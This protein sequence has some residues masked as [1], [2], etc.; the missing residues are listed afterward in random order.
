[1]AN[2]AG[3]PVTATRVDFTAPSGSKPLIFESRLQTGEVTVVRCRTMPNPAGGRIVSPQT[4]IVVPSGRAFDLDW[5]P[6]EG[7][8]IQSSTIGRG[9][10]MLYEANVPAWKR[11]HGSPVI[12]VMAVRPEFLERIGEREFASGT[13][14]HLRTHVGF[15]DPTADNLMRLAERELD[16]GGL[17]GRLFLEGLATALSV[18]LLQSYAGE[19]GPER[20]HGGLAAAALK[21]VTDY[22][23]AHL[24]EELALADLATLAGLSAHHFGQAFKRTT[25]L[26]PHQ[27]VIHCR[28]G[29]A[30]ELLRDPA[31]TVAEVAVAVGFSNQSHLTRHF[32]RLTG[33]T[34][35]R[36]RR[37]LR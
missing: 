28:V 36:F 21:Q 4:T 18:H 16:E 13:T 11:W 1:M 24:A 22:I 34:P 19:A 32:R 5:R 31:L 15:D 14:K 29:R 12:V 10:V 6:P 26:P 2:D 30:R 23:E 8:P 37:G 25:G 20:R 35:A 3:K 17:N 7:G 33:T 9:R 27:Y